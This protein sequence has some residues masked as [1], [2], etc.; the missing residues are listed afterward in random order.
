[1]REDGR[2]SICVQRRILAFVFGTIK[3]NE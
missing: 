2:R 1:M 3:S